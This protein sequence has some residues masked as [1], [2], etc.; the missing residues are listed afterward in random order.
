MAC[1]LSLL[2]VIL[3]R[4]TRPGRGVSRF[5]LLAPTSWTKQTRNHGR[6]SIPNMRRCK[7]E[8]LCKIGGP[9]WTGTETRSSHDDVVIEIWSTGCTL[10]EWVQDMT[11]EIAHVGK[12]ARVVVVNWKSGI[13]RPTTIENGP[14]RIRLFSFGMEKVRQRVRAIFASE[15]ND[16]DHIFVA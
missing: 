1:R 12:T 16:N 10:D 2:A 3:S 9:I 7:C 15:W 5:V 11:A 14:R 6:L 4:R 8:F 13:S